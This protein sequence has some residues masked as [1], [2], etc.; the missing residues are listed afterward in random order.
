MKKWPTQKQTHGTTQKH[1]EDATN[2]CKYM[3]KQIYEEK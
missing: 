1:V 2:S 3:Y